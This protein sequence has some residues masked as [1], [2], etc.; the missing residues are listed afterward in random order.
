M[1]W[2]IRLVPPEPDLEDEAAKPMP[3]EQCEDIS[4]PA[5]PEDQKK[6][7]LEPRR[8]ELDQLK[9][10]LSDVAEKTDKDSMFE[11]AL[12]EGRREDYAQAAETWLMLLELHQKSGD[13][14]PLAVMFNLASILNKQEKYS[15][16]E[17]LLRVV[18]PQLRNGIGKDSQ[19]AI[20]TMRALSVAL[21]GQQ[22]YEEAKVL[23]D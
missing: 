20:G 2:T 1:S 10:A 22:K 19:Q 14:E 18:L 9:S 8:S 17:E 4:R 3:S 6:P 5:P 11:L 12:E 23:N 15:Q 13:Q 21:L 16:A 7:Q